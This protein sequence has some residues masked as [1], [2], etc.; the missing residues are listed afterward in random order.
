M[1]SGVIMVQFVLMHKQQK[2]FEIVIQLMLT[3][4][5]LN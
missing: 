1:S 3:V 4:K 5:M 2:Q